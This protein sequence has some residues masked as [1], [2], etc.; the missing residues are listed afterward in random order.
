MCNQI[1]ITHGDV[2]GGVAWVFCKG[3]GSEHH[4]TETA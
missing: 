1:V 2:V 3:K 4:E